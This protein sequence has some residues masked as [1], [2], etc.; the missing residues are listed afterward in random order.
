MNERVG[1]AGI[2]QWYRHLD[3]GE[4]FV[5]TGIDAGSGAIEIQNFDGDL[6][7]IEAN[8]WN[9]LPL[10]LVETPEDE[11]GPLD[12]DPED[13]GYSETDMKA[14]DWDEPLQAFATRREAW[15]E[16]TPEDETDA[17]AEGPPS[18]ESLLEHAVAAVRAP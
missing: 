8:V 4:M 15:E 6:D 9:T 11:T 17:L 2:G 1:A 12:L 14:Q 13:L 5:V 3:K 18:E 16:T 10:E 7:E